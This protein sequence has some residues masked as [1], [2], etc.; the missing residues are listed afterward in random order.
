[1][2]RSRFLRAVR[3]AALLLAVKCLAQTAPIPLDQ[4][5]ADRY[6]GYYLVRPQQA[7][8]FWREGEHFYFNTVGTQQRAQTV[9]EGPNRFSY[10]N[11]AVSLS[12]NTGA[13]GEVAS[14]TVNRAG[15]EIIAPR[16]DEATAKSFP[17]PGAASTANPPA[18]RTWTLMAGVTVKEITART[19][20]T[21]DYWPCFSP[22]GKSVLFSRTLDNGRTWRLF[23]VPAAGGTAEPFAT[24]PVSATRASWSASTDRIVF[25]GDTPDGK[26]SGIWTVRGDGREAHVIPTTGLVA[27]GYPSWYPDG[28]SIGVGDAA[29]NILYRVQVE[30][31]MSAAITRQE[32]VLAGMSSVAPDGKW[33]AFAGQ[34]NSGQGYRQE[35]NQIWL[36]DGSGASRTLET[37]PL[38][39]R[40]P[41]WSPDG[42]RLA[43]ESSR[44]SPDGLYAVFLIN[45]DGSGLVKVSDYALNASHPVFS[46]DGSKLVFAVGNPSSGATSIAVVA[47]PH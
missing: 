20:G 32:E 3:W 15:T 41:T 38:Q 19:P 29:R 33:V 26:G 17:L 2:N 30:N 16:I 47:L 31:G 7:M 12:F 36:V 28:R 45:R 4:A 24:L 11:G 22:D 43:F 39:G 14:L 37:P 13:D 8:R 42:K 21:M 44:G 40:T 10:N 9:V 1:M 34:K 18:A 5:A 25:N 35:N 46:P 27:P 23:L 6:A